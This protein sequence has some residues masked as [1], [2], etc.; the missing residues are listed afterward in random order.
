MGKKKRQIKKTR[1]KEKGDDEE[2][3]KITEKREDYKRLIKK[4][5][6]RNW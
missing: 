1:K 6:R 4:R 2:L 5:G 3:M